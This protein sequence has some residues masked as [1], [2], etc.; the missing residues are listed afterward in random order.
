MDYKQLFNTNRAI[1]DTVTSTVAFFRKQDYDSGIRGFKNIIAYLQTVANILITEDERLRKDGIIVDNQYLMQLLSDIMKAQEDKDYILLADLLELTLLPFFI[2]MQEM[3]RQ[4]KKTLYNDYFEINI[5]ALAGQD[6]VLAKRIKKTYESLKRKADTREYTA[7]NGV[8]YSVEDTQFGNPTLKVV[9]KGK[10]YYLHSNSDPVSEGKRLADTCWNGDAERINVCGAGLLYHAF[11]IANKSLL[12]YPVHIY[13]P[14]CHVLAI[15]LTTLNITEFLKKN[16]IYLHLDESMQEFTEAISN[17]LW[18]F[19]IHYPSLQNIGNTAVRNSM[20]KF[21]IAENTA[22]NQSR[23]LMINFKDNIKKLQNNTNQV[24]VIDEILPNL[25]GKEIY[26]IA[27]GPS[28]DKNIE[29]L[30]G[31]SADSLLFATGTVFIKMMKM[32]IRPDFV[33][34]TDPNDRVVWQIWQQEAETIPMLLLSTANRKFAG[35][36]VG[37]KYLIFQ[38]DFPEAEKI[39]GQLDCTIFE[40]GGSV[41]TMA[42][43][44]AIRGK[45]SRIIFLG[46]DLAYTDNLAH[47]EGT[48]NRIA[49]DGDELI[50]VKAFGGGYVLTDYK[51]TIYREW[52]ERRIKEIGE[53]KIE[54]INATEGGAYIQGMRHEPLEAVMKNRMNIIKGND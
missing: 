8:I 4:M 25:A 44:V 37:P 1:L 53:S 54:I 13:E 28:L 52:M 7:P 42:L 11:S 46:L 14:D 24:T 5:E 33:I 45:A 43:D 3:I 23:L 18:G 29:L 19:L 12:A 41:S 47:A 36:Y 50:R 39:A 9:R 16:Y 2:L 40:T 49:N 48:S 26:I 30:R 32:G 27:A 6:S 17:Q 38:K 51:F 22:Q 10:S 20:E 15:A 34:I 35:T 31:R 21:F